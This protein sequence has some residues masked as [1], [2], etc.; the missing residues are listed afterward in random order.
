M[1]PDVNPPAASVAWAAAV[2]SPAAVVT[3][4]LLACLSAPLWAQSLDGETRGRPMSDE[5]ER[6]CTALS[7]PLCL[8]P[9][10]WRAPACRAAVALTLV[11][12]CQ[13]GLPM[14]A[15]RAAFAA[16]R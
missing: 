14:R 12:T 16:L 11:K 1:T 3:A 10:D 5:P 7:Q 15:S 2:F 9:A 4:G 6:A 13:P 8:L